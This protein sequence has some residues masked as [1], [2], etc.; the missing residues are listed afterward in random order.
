MNYVSA[1]NEYHVP[2]HVK[3]FQLKK[4]GVTDAKV[5]IIKQTDKSMIW[6]LNQTI[7][8]LILNVKTMRTR[9]IK[10]GIVAAFVLIAG[11][12][13]YNS[14]KEVALSDVAME[15]VEALASGEEA[16][17]TFSHVEKDQSTNHLDCSGNGSLC[18][19]MN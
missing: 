19:I 11:Y 8:I 18:C 10:V 1:N 6:S 2:L 9:T 12:T 7:I 15:N 3:P 5:P 13:V 16:T 14:Q 4:G 17:C